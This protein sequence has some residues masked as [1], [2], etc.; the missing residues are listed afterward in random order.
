MPSDATTKPVVFK[1]DARSMVLLNEPSNGRPGTVLK[2]FLH[3]GFKQLL[4]YCIGLHPAQKER[5]AAA[6]LARRGV[7]VVPITD[8]HLGVGERGQPVFHVTLLTEYHGPSLQQA[9]R[10]TPPDNHSRLLAAVAPLVRQLLDRRVFFKDLKSSN[11]VLGP[12]AP[13][14]LNPRL[15]DVGSARRGLSADQRRRMLDMLRHTCQDDGADLNEL[16]AHLP[17]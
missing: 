7:F 16:D 11:I 3:A 8:I 2:R 1:H 5:R 4:T 10:D 14:T 17:H 9:L 13:H 12:D 15:I 6:W